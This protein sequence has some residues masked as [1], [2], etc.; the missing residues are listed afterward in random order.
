MRLDAMDSIN[1]FMA[2]GHS[3]P[4][5]LFFLDVRISADFRSEYALSGAGFSRYTMNVL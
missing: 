3:S 5:K 4:E 2:N 1:D